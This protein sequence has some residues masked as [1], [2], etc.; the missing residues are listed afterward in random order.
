MNEQSLKE[1]IKNISAK[2][3]R[4]FVDIWKTL[5]LERFLV[6]LSHSSYY[7]KFVLK[8]GLLLS[9]YLYIGRETKD[10]D[11]LAE[12]IDVMSPQI[13]LAMMEICKTFIDDGFKISFLNISELDHIH[14]NYRNRHSNYTLAK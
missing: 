9:K 3:N 11:L 7:D 1:K 5:I 12:K 2:Q 10:I 8:G 4:P 13:E 6:R 14:M